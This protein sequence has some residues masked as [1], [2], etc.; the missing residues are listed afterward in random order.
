MLESLVQRAMTAAVWSLLIG[1]RIFTVLASLAL[2]LQ[3]LAPP[4]FMVSSDPAVRGLVVCT[5]HG[6]LVV[7]PHFGKPA[8]APKSTSPG[9]CVFAAHGAATPPPIATLI[10]TAEPNAGSSAS[11]AVFDVAP[12]RGLA[13]PPPPSQAPPP[14]SI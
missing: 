5:G 10:Q 6:P 8:K 14:I 9:P 3:I 12:S 1:R 4:G 2:L 13:A 11:E 7:S